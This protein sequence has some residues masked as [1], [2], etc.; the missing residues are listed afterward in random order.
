MLA[1]LIKHRIWIIAAAV[2]IISWTTPPLT[3]KN[4][5]SYYVKFYTPLATALG[6]PW[7]YA[8]LSKDLILL[9][10]Y[11]LPIIFG[12]TAFVATGI[13][14]L[15]LI[16]AAGLYD[17]NYDHVKNTF[18]ANMAFYI[19]GAYGAIPGIEIYRRYYI[20]HD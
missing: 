16:N 14:Y 13:I 2:V 1:W 19:P 3:G 11:I 15:P 17:D 4:S 18:L 12:M 8:L 7:L 20:R 10:K 5:G 6:F 9:E